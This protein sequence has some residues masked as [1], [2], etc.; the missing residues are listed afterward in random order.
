MSAECRDHGRDTREAGRVQARAVLAD[1]RSAAA[2]AIDRIL[3]M[4][5]RD[6][7][8]WK[9]SRRKKERTAFRRKRH[10]PHAPP[11]TFT[12][13]EPVRLSLGTT[14]RARRPGRA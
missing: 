1:R 5:K 10:V 9:Q 6:R 3:L 12:G 8:Q 13:R 2:R 11:R 4:P 14:A 7:N